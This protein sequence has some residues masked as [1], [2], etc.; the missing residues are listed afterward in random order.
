M[1]K[2][3][4]ELRH[5]WFPFL[6]L[7]LKEL[8]WSISFKVTKYIQSVNR[9]IRNC[10]MTNEWGFCRRLNSHETFV[11]RP[12]N[13]VTSVKSYRT[14]DV[15][16]NPNV[17]SKTISKSFCSSKYRAYSCKWVVEYLPRN[18]NRNTFTLLQMTLGILCF[19]FRL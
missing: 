17:H 12:L 13:M 10:E 1:A 7:P 4:V 11:K 2:V 3:C 18:I 19:R 6:L 5:I 15:K 14:K 8:T 9:K 16:T